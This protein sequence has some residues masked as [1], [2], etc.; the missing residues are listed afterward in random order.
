MLRQFLYL[1]R[2]LV[3]EFLAQLEGGIFDESRETT[4]TEGKGGANMRLGAGPAGIG[5]DKSKTTQSASEAVM[6]QTAASEFDRLYS[7]LESNG[8]QVYD[9]VDTKFEELPIRRKDIVEVDARLQMSGV[10]R[11]FELVGTMTQLL[12]LMDAFGANTELD[13]DTLQAMSAMSALGSN[14]SAPVLV[15]TV[16]GDCGLKLALPLRSAGVLTKEWDVE[17]TVILKVQR[18]LRPGDSEAVGDPLGGLMK[19][20]PQNVKDEFLAAFTGPDAAQLGIGD[21]QISY[22]GLVATPI[23]IFR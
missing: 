17:A 18:V 20:L 22:P 8:L 16:P 11:M 9:V 2:D 4:A 15:G 14:T 5:A 13:D 19:V 7:Q 23:A 21:A 10:D 6:K 1:D 3:R 12:P